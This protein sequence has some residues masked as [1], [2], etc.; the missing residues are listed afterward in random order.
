MED[1][2][3]PS[4]EKAPISK[5]EAQRARM[6]IKSY[7]EMDRGGRAADLV[8]EMVT[9]YGKR[10]KPNEDGYIVLPN[11]NERWYIAKRTA[12]RVQFGDAYSFR[13]EDMTLDFQHMG[14]DGVN[15]IIETLDPEAAIKWHKKII[16]EMDK[17]GW[18]RY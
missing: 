17:R 3:Q 12:D 6:D 13:P 7:Q 4:I 2:I 11:K 9:Y 5:A 8:E 18:R 16:T 10:I 15:P 14:P 1:E